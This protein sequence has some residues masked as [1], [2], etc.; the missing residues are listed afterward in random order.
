MVNLVHL[1]S[2]QYCNIS[3]DVEEEG[4]IGD[5][6]ILAEAITVQPTPTKPSIEPEVAFEEAED[7]EI[8]ARITADTGG[9]KT[10]ACYNPDA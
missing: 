4:E 1:L 5:V 7:G 8:C 9:G 6:E 3:S 10:T 2:N